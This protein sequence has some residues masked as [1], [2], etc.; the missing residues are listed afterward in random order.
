M[1]VENDWM[2]KLATETAVTPNITFLRPR[3]SVIE[4]PI[5]EPTAKPTFPSEKIVSDNH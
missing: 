1:L 2:A 5:K 3:T 4:P